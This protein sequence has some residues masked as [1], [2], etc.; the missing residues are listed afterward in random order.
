MNKKN[1]SLIIAGVVMSSIGNVSLHA[2]NLTA[3]GSVGPKVYF[4]STETGTGWD[5]LMEVR[6][7]TSYGL[8]FF[9]NVTSSNVK[10][11]EIINSD[12]NKNSFLVNSSGDI[13]LADGSVFIDRS[14]NKVGIGTTTPSF[15]L[16]IMTPG[17]VGGDVA[18]TNGAD[19]WWLDNNHEWFNIGGPVNRVFTLNTNAPSNNFYM[20]ANGNIGIGTIT[21]KA[22]LEVNGDIKATWSGS[23]TVD[24]GLKVLTL[25]SA[26]NSAAG[27][28]SDAGFGLKNA[29][30]DFQW[31][32]RTY[33]PGEGFT[34][35]KLGTG[36]GE[37][38][39]KSPTDDFRDARMIVGGV[40]VF[41]SGHLVTASSRELKTNIKLLDTQAA[42]DAFHQLQPVSYEYK[43][44]KGEP[45]VGFIA[46]D[47]PDLV[48]MPSRKALDSTEIVAVLTKV[49]QEQDKVLSETRTELKAAQEKIAKLEKMQQRLAKVESL[50]TNLALKTSA[51]EQAKLSLN[52]K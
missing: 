17:S 50:L 14:V 1:I 48:A 19:T 45:V 2:G 34:A 23:N 8:S 38:V 27:K 32:F 36:G 49:V 25:L 39:I 28:S 16:E 42:M 33:G 10:T 15:P 5:W 44:Q 11:F 4:D 35:T 30:L 12:N 21:P 6:G 52:T 9:N 40:T 29:K 47:I 37:L 20:I 26:D 3:N 51:E 43:A 22:K 24:D 13:N 46:E 31:N 18:L 41:E 7:S